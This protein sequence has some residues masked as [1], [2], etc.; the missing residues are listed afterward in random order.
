MRH[1]IIGNGAAGNAAAAAIRER[2]PAAEVLILGDE[3]QPAYFRPLITSLIDEVPPRDLSFPE[4]P[5]ESPQVEVRLGARVVGLDAAAQQLT[6]EDGQTCSF[7]RLLLATGAAALVPDIPGWPGPGTFVLRTMADAQALARATKSATKAVVIGAGRVGL[8]AGLS[9]RQLGLAVT[10]VEQGPHVAPMQFDEV[11]GAILGQALEARGIGLCLGNTVTEVKREGGQRI[12]GVVLEDGRFLEAEMVVAAVGVRPNLKLAQK[13]G[14]SVNQ[15][16]VVDEYLRTSVP[17]IFAAGDA[18]ETRDLVTGRS[19]VSG[20]WTNAMEMGR[21]AGSNMTGAGLT[22]PGAWGVGNSLEVAGIPTVAVGLTNP[23]P[24]EAYEIYQTRQ[25]NIYR[26]LVCQDEVLVGA[27]LIGDIDSAGVYAGL[28]KGKTKIRR[29]S[30]LLQ[31][32]RRSVA[33]RLAAHVQGKRA[34]GTRIV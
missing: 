11:S 33:S 29:I 16:I 30:Q 15:G 4:G 17:E 32:P 34:V 9:L 3:P 26:K 18:A 21:L 31:Q 5:A 8:K 12:Q 23:V 20:L 7:D 24:A 27:L 1:V 25:G 28:I 2:D 14:L 19:L 13:A 10:L 22:Y 6:L